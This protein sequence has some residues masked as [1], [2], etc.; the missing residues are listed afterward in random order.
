[1]NSQPHIGLMLGTARDGRM[2][3]SVFTYI[4]EKLEARDDVHVTAYDVRNFSVDKTIYHTDNNPLTQA[5]RDAVQT[6]DAFIIVTPEYNHSYPG[7]LKLWIDQAAIAA[8]AYKPIMV[9]GVS[10]GDF[11]GIRVV[12]Q[13]TTLISNFKMMQAGALY[14]P[15]VGEF[16]N[17]S[18]EE[19]DTH[20]ADRVSNSIDT[21]VLC[22]K[23]LSS[24]R[25]ELS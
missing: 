19:K 13:F 17:M 14:F 18:A 25:A 23:H 9:A 15:K 10:I 3:E 2:S 6:I 24:L 4:H 22:H 8:Y 1:M 5:W 16:S 20:Y 7:E 12:E 21:M 11:G